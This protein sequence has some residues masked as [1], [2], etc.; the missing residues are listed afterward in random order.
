[1]NYFDSYFLKKLLQVQNFDKN[2]S[3]PKLSIVMPSFNQ[4]R[5]IEKS[6][7]SILNQGYPNLQLIIIDGGST[8]GT[9][10]IIKR[11]SKF[12]YYWVSEKDRGQSDAL[13][14]GFK[15]A[16]GEIYGWLNSDDIYL[17][18]TFLYCIKTLLDNEN[19]LLVYG[20]WLTIDENDNFIDLNHAFDFNLNHF[21]YEGFH[22]NSQSMLW[23]AELH[24]Q[25]SGFDINL[26]N[27]MDYQMILEFGL[28]GEKFFFRIDKPLGVFRRHNKQKTRPLI[29]ATVIKEHLFLS[30]KYQYSD[31][32]SFIGNL[33][34][35][36]F[37]FRRIFWYLKRGGISNLIK[38]INLSFQ[39][40][41]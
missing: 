20:D 33:K 5:Y 18:Q 24:K 29:S 8:D 12:I 23:R 36:Y 13:N 25:F 6:I 26:H 22:L 38:R 27:T 3:W 16:D 37:R 9:I 40:N 31:K 7:L 19:K 41:K 28:V 10:E 32:Y 35:I 30:K 39:N 15:I 4:C 11:Y 21:K 14:K 34:R 1:M 17:P 2:K